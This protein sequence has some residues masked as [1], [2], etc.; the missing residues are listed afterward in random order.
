MRKPNT[1]RSLTEGA[2]LAAITVLLSLLGAYFMPYLFFVTPVP[3]IILVYRH[4]MRPGILVAVTSALLAGIVI[5]MVPTMIFLLIL[6]LVG[7]AM[8]GGLR[9]GFPPHRILLI[10]TA[11][12]VIALIL[13]V[14]VTTLVLDI[15]VLETSF[16]ALRQSLEQALRMY[17]RFGVEEHPFLKPNA[18]DEFVRL[19]KLALPAA[20][21][22]TATMMTFVNYWLARL[23]LNRV[24]A[25]LPWIKPFRSWRFPWYLAWGYI[26]GHGLLLASRGMTETNV[27]FALGLNLQIL[28]NYV[29]LLQGLAILWFFFEKARV[30]KL[31]RWIVIVFLFNPM[32]TTIIVWAGVL[33]TWFNFRKLGEDEPV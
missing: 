21:L 27:W 25:K 2:M 14:A 10:G 31:V 28:F 26:L 12:S 16:E 9:E 6:G 24:G 17:E 15:S 32:I 13:M 22:T 1:T 30:P 11:T 18:I 20:L 4:G 3:L 8:G 19:L 33:D 29:F 5:S 23:I 7:I